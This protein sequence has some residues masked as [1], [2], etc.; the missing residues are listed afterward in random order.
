MSLTKLTENLNNVSSLPDKPA[1]NSNELKQVFD[2][3][4]NTI[5]EYINTILTEEM[6][7]IIADLTQKVLDILNGNN[8]A[9]YLDNTKILWSEEDET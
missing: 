8:K 4:G 2:E 5:K 6:D 1:L 3:S 7:K 9:I